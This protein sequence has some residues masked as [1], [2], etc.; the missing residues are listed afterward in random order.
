MSP[1]SVLN[2]NLITKYGIKCSGVPKLYNQENFGAGG[3]M[4]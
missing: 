3:P 4:S 1:K 2:N